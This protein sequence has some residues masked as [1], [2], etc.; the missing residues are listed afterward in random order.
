VLIR[1]NKPQELEI[2]CPPPRQKASLQIT[3]PPV[4]EDLR[5]EAVSVDVR[6][7]ERPVTAGGYNWAPPSTSVQVLSF[8]ARTGKATGLVQ[9]EYRPADGFVDLHNV[10]AEDCLLFITSGPVGIQY[11]LTLLDPDTR[12]DRPR[13]VNSL[14]FPPSGSEAP[15]LQRTAEAG[16]NRWQFELPKELLAAARERL[17]SQAPHI[18][19][20][21][22]AP[23]STNPS[24]PTPKKPQLLIKLVPEAENGPPVKGHI[25]SVRSAEMNAAAERIVAGKDEFYVFDS[26]PPDQYELTITLADS[27]NQFCTRTLFVDDE[28][29]LELTIVCPGPRRKVPIALTIQPLPEKLARLNLDV[30]M[31]VGAGPVEIDL[32]RWDAP[33]LPTQMITFDAKTGLPREVDITTPLGQ[34]HFNLRDLPADER[35]VFLPAGTVEYRFRVS[36]HVDGVGS[37]PVFNWP[38]ASHEETSLKHVIRADKKSW[39]LELPQEYLNQLLREYHDLGNEATRRELYGT[40]RVGD[41]TGDMIFEITPAG[42][43]SWK[44]G[45]QPDD[46]LTFKL[47]VSHDPCWIDIDAMQGVFRL[48][49]DELILCIGPKRPTGLDPAPGEQVE[50]YVLKRDQYVPK[51]GPTLKNDDTDSSVGDPTPE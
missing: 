45:K 18:T 7:D 8:E 43:R 46:W 39:K 48:K 2:V 13:S 1:D 31:I 49:G 29:P 25:V 42:C 28:K 24:V 17:N 20:T 23:R 16:E 15:W 5:E 4:P 44:Q 32:F 51:P 30:Q 26:L 35:R 41:G 50:R 14:E 21:E 34:Q 9:D 10:K 12:S 27:Q 6:I 38:N 33:H 47:D 37:V 19:S 36:E 40:W 11:Q 22:P 3:V